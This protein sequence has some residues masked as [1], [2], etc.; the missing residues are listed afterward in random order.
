MG[1]VIKIPSHA[2]SWAFYDFANTIYSAIV[3]TIYLPLYVTNL[4]GKHAPLGMAATLS[5]V[6]SGFLIPYLGKLTDRTGNTKSYLLVSTLACVIA[7][8]TLSFLRSAHSL[9]IIFILANLLYHCSLVFYNS[10]LPL[11]APPERQGF[12]SGMGTGLGYL[13]VLFALPAAHVVDTVWG[14]PWVFLV[15]ALLFFLFSLPLFLHVPDREVRVPVHLDLKDSLR[16]LAENRTL[17]FF[18]AG[19]F[20]LLDVLNAVILW[21]SVFLKKN[22]SL[23]QGLIIQTFLALNFSAFLFG[24]LLGKLTDRIGYK[25]NLIL[26]AASLAVT[27][28]AVALIR[29]YQA[30]FF[31]IILFG[32]AGA[33]GAWT[34]GRKAVAELAPKDRIGEFFGLY[35]LTTKVSAIGSTTISVLAD[36]FGFRWAVSSQLVSLACAVFFLARLP[37]AGQARLP[38]PK[39]Q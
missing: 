30:A 27:I 2:Y 26:S 3:V 32:G 35:G 34:A 24:I 4:T 25:R 21:L 39:S 36:F 10:L 38:D 22:F 11:V 19:N 23:S 13:G 31:F 9:L 17:L 6:L 16:L 18:L 14:R 7:T 8:A 5:M 1:S 20:F 28:L 33:A 12:V 15:A 37:D 29:S